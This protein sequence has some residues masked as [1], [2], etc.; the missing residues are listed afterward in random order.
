MS[1][2]CFYYLFLLI[3]IVTPT[4]A[5]ARIS[6]DSQSIRLLVSPVLTG[7]LVFWLVVLA[8]GLLAVFVALACF[9]SSAGLVSLSFLFVVLSVSLLPVSGSVS[10]FSRIL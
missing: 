9:V 3:E 5:I 8:A 10:S 7:V 2:S 6:R 4:V 1:S